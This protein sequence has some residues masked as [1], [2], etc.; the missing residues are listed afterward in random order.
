MEELQQELERVKAQE[1]AWEFTEFNEETA[2]KMGLWLRSQA[3]ENHYPIAISI[4]LNHR[5]LF[6]CSMPGAACVNEQW[7]Q[8]KENL[9]YLFQKSSY[10][11]ALSMK[12]KKDT[13]VNRYGLRSEDYAAA[14][15]SIPLLVKGIG[16]VGTVTVSGL[17]EWEDHE[18]VV[19][20]VRNMIQG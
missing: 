10:E 18:L 6:G 1:K 7:I 3:K 12:L 19:G 11:M 14:G 4:T 13:L 9:V 16:M 8:R 15:G 20:A 2:W 5:R 17:S